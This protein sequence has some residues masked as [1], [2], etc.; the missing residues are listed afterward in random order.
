MARDEDLAI[1]QGWLMPPTWEIIHLS[2]KRYKVSLTFGVS[3]LKLTVSWLLEVSILDILPSFSSA[4]TALKALRLL[5]SIKI[6]SPATRNKSH[7]YLGVSQK[8]KGPNIQLGN[9]H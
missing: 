1:L 3:R 7:Q 5:R 9:L 6:T 8:M 4:R 2:W